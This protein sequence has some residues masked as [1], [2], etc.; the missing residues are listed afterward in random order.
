MKKIIFL[1]ILMIILSYMGQSLSAHFY[2]FKA[3][4]FQSVLSLL[5]TNVLYILVVNV[6]IYSLEMLRLHL[7]GRAFDLRLNWKDCFGAVSLNILFAWITP[8]AILGAPA[9]AYYLFRKGH[10]LAE[11]ITIAFI[12]SFSIIFISAVTTIIVYSLN[13][14]EV[15]VNPALIDK[16]FYVLMILA[17]YIASL[18]ALS[19]L[20]LRIRNKVKFVASITN[21]IRKFLSKGKLLLLP[22]LGLGALINFFLVSFI[23]YA[24]SGYYEN[25]TPLISQTMLFLSYLLLMPTPGASGLAEI[26]APAFFSQNI[27]LQEMISVVTAMRISTIG[28]QIVI[29]TLF[30]FYFFKGHISFAELTDFKKSKMKTSVNGSHEQ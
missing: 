11:S 23:P 26:G 12:R 8:G 25:L 14:Q 10:P 9:L 6:V 7:I 16:I 18:V 1:F 17:I 3:H 2:E 20:P 29:G 15:V 21:Q 27:P 4:S 5:R 24:T 22:I 30:M 19:Y 13:L 28:I